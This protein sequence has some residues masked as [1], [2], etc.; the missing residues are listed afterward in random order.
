MAKS[1][2]IRKPTFAKNVN[3]LVQQEPLLNRDEL[4]ALDIAESLVNLNIL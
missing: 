3:K 4:L 2:S 1:I